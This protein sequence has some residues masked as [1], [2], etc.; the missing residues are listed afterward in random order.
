LVFK[1]HKLSRI[2]KLSL[3]ILIICGGSYSSISEVHR[4]YAQTIAKNLKQ[5]KDQSFS[6]QIDVFLNSCIKAS[7]DESVN[8]F[9]RYKEIMVRE[10]S[11][12]R[13]YFV[14]YKEVENLLD[15]A[16]NESMDSL[17]LFTHPLLQNPKSFAIVFN[18]RLLQQINKNF[19]F[20]GLFNISIP[21]ID[22]GYA[23]KMNFFVIGQGKFIVGYDR[24]AKIKHPDY[25]FVTGK[26]DYRELFIMDAGKDSEGKSG[27]F[28]I[29]GLSKPDGKLQWMKGPLNVDIHSL[30][31]TSDPGG[32]N[33][34]LIEYDL[35]GIKYKI[36]DPI[37]IEKLYHQ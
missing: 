37:P 5:T 18:E 2:T 3:I 20:H 30:R 8:I 29:K 25:G 32:H 19:D 7:K 15:Q 24:N 1:F 4:I 23:V 13:L 14:S 31:I 36:I 16:V 21:S 26:Y 17:T 35:L 27:L 10:L 34:I 22:D 6:K 12:E 28:N 33:Q 11:L 9:G